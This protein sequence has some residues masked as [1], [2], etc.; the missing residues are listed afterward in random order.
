MQTF[1]AAPRPWAMFGWNATL[2]RAAAQSG[3]PT[4]DCDIRQQPWRLQ[5]Y[6]GQLAPES[7][8]RVSTTLDLRTPGIDFT[9]LTS[10]T[11][12]A[13]SHS[14]ITACNTTNI[15]LISV[16]ISSA[17]GHERFSSAHSRHQSEF[18]CG[19]HPRSRRSVG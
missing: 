1:T 16:D 3:R 15:V 4:V 13:A 6:R 19:R 5:A 14:S 17:S 11:V 9:D 7:A 8:G 18:Q 2:S 12:I 10:G